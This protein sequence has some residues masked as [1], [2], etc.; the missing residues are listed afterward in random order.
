MS[1]FP[2]RRLSYILELDILY[3]ISRQKTYNDENI[4]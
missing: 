4:L 2:E 3:K 1:S